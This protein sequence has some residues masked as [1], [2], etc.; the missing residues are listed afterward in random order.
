M[1]KIKRKLLFFDMARIDFQILYQSYYTVIITFVIVICRW[2]LRVRA[3]VNIGSF[4]R[5]RA[6]AIIRNLRLPCLLGGGSASEHLIKYNRSF[7]PRVPSFALQRFSN[8]SRFIFVC[9]LVQ[10]RC[11]R[12]RRRSQNSWGRTRVRESRTWLPRVVRTGP[13]KTKRI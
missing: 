5:A 11:T 1:K 8:Y 7:I 9:T 12:Y 13:R 10:T 4:V 6:Q 2:V 3:S